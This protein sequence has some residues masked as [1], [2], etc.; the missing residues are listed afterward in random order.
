MENFFEHPKVGDVLKEERKKRKLSLEEIHQKTRVSLRYLQAIEEGQW[1][2]FPAEVYRVGFLKDYAAY[3]KMDVEKVVQQ[4]REDLQIASS[5]LT[6]PPTESADKPALKNSKFSDYFTT[7]TLIILVIFSAFYL[8]FY[9][10]RLAAKNVLQKIEATNNVILNFKIQVHRPVW[11]RVVCDGNLAFEGHA[12]QDSLK[13]WNANKEIVVRIGNYQAL[14]MFLNEHALKIQPKHRT[15]VI[16]IVLNHETL[17]GLQADSQ[18]FLQSVSTTTA[19]SIST[20]A[21]SIEVST[22]AS[23]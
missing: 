11:V 8:R 19:P 9:F 15:S 17:Q 6:Q 18:M 2:V 14:S 5:K 22:T 20:S 3:L 7:A 23:L 12:A 10:K 4:Y 21:T 13:F 1:D 16:E